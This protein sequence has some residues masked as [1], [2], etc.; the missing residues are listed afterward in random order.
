MKTATKRGLHL[1]GHTINERVQYWFAKVGLV[2]D[3]RP[4]TSHG[5][6]AGG[7]TDLAESGATDQE[8]EEAGRWAK[9]SAIPRTVYV[10]PAQAAKKNPFDK[11]PVHNP[12]AEEQ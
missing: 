8:L 10:R 9:G 1:R 4:V 11:V 12:T 2:S 6:R 3:G 7:A 5:L